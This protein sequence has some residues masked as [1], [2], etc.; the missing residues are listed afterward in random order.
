MMSARRLAAG[1]LGALSLGS[2]TA[3]E[4]SGQTLTTSIADSIRV[5]TPGTPVSLLFTIQSSRGT[6]SEAQVSAPRSWRVLTGGGP[7]PAGSH[8][9]AYMVGVFVP[10]TAEAG[11]YAVTLSARDAQSTTMSTGWV[12]VPAVRSIS[13]T[14]VESPQLLVAG[15]DGIAKF[16]LANRG[17]VE[18]MVK[19][20]LRSTQSKTADTLSVR[21]AA[22][23]SREISVVIPAPKTTTSAV[24]SVTS[25]TA[26]AS[27]HAS[28][29][30]AASVRVPI[31]PREAYAPAPIQF[32]ESHIRL[33]G[34]SS[35]RGGNGAE[36]FGS[37]T[38]REGGNAQLEYLARRINGQ[39]SMFGDRSEYRVS[40]SSPRFSVTA[41]DQVYTLSSLSESGR[42]G[43][44]VATSVASRGWTVGG[45]SSRDATSGSSRDSRALFLNRDFGNG[46]FLGMNYFNRQP[47]GS[48]VLTAHTSIRSLGVGTI[49]GEIGH[50][51]NSRPAEAYMV[52]AAGR[53][54]RFQ[55]SVYRQKSD[56][57]Y[58]GSTR[59]TETF[60]ASFDARPVN[61]IRVRAAANDYRGNRTASVLRIGATH[62]WNGLVSVA[63]RNF[64]TLDGMRNGREDKSF[65]AA[66]KRTETLGSARVAVRSKSR[67]LTVSAAVGSAESGGDRANRLSR[68]TAQASVRRGTGSNLSLNFES[69]RGG[70]LFLPGEKSEVRAG[71][72]GTFAS[73]LGVF[74][75]TAYLTEHTLERRVRDTNIEAVWEKDLSQ[76]TRVSVRARAHRNPFFDSSD[77]NAV[78]AEYTIPFGMPMGPSRIRG[79]IAGR[80]V[81]ADTRT[82][83]P[84]AVIQLGT[85]VSIT[86]ARGRFAF[87]V[88]AERP[89]LLNFG[90][91]AATAGL[92]PLES[93]PL[94]IVPRIGRTQTFEVAMTKAGHIEG[95]VNVFVPAPGFKPDDER[96]SVRDEKATV[97]VR[98]EAWQDSEVHRVHTGAFGRFTF[99]DLRPGRWVIRIADSELPQLST[100]E[101][102]SV[103]VNVA[104]G[105][106][107]TA[108]V[109]IVPRRRKVRLVQI[110]Q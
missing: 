12:V 78:R 5:A 8:R 73:R 40:L 32:I 35:P 6:A 36:I 66:P 58:G 49:E 21:L 65:S 63:L 53:F 108:V 30:A 47:D 20:K 93:L 7:L 9:I 103:I 48:S 18:T 83:I 91:S 85:Q 94:T 44:G 88:D 4:A 19:L 50:A 14:A 45:F 15:N 24:Q 59:G 84:G 31:M 28:V 2:V 3:S 46:I 57:G 90:G 110:G 109:N 55:Y 76:G 67:A 13:L 87:A 80:V 71:I 100:V 77:D 52:S 60:N 92:I 96:P 104:R 33:I 79:R 107:Q 72:S 17:N 37:G 11:K 39:G 74:S 101:G 62:H 105:E 34:A 42:F 23:E 89:V 54:D 98:V 86:D 64:L 99:T 27:G 97:Q 56:A 69:L 22:A 16:L 70:T 61:G 68:Y 75:M 51:I 41:G 26:V 81:D 10:S 29:T 1:F 106:T 38:L 95:S 43:R 102:D 25:V 82:A